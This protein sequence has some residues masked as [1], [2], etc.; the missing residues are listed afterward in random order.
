MFSIPQFTLSH[1]LLQFI[2]IIE[3]RLLNKTVEEEAGVLLKSIICIITVSLDAGRDN[4]NGIK[5]FKRNIDK[6]DC[7]PPSK[8]SSSSSTF[9]TSSTSSSS[10]SSSSSFSSSWINSELLSCIKR[11]KLLQSEEGVFISLSGLRDASVCKSLANRIGNERADK[12]IAIAA[13]TTESKVRISIKSSVSQNILIKDSVYCEDEKDVERR[14]SLVSALTPE[15]RRLCALLS[16]SPFLFAHTVIKKLIAKGASNLAMDV[17]KS[18]ES[19]DSSA[20]SPSPLFFAVDSPV[21]SFNSEGHVGGNDLSILLEAAVTLC[22]VVAKQL[23][24]ANTNRTGAGDR[25][26]LTSLEAITRPFVV[27][28]DLLKGVASTCPPEH[29]GR[30]LDILNGSELVLAVHERMEGA[31]LHGQGQDHG[32]HINRLD[33]TQTALSGAGAGKFKVSEGSFSR[34]GILMA[35]SSVLG[36]V[37]RY[38]AA[39]IRRRLSTIASTT[40][41]ANG[42]AA[43]L[44]LEELVCVLQRSENHLLAVRV[45]LSSWHLSDTKA[46]LLRSSL[47]SLSRKVLSYR[48]IDTALAVAC[49][50]MLPYDAMVRELK[51]AVPSIQSD[52]SRLRTVAS[53]GEGLARL[54]DQE[55]LLVVFQGLQTNAKWWHILSQHGVKIDPRAFQSSDTKQRDLCVRAVVPELLELSN[56]DLEQAADYCRQFDIEPEFAS[57]SYIEKIMLQSPTGV[58]SGNIL[59]VN[60][61]VWAR[62]VRKATVN[63]DERA[64]LGTLRSLL[65]RIHPLDYER[66]RFMCTWIVAALA[67]EVETEEDITRQRSTENLEGIA[68]GEE[69]ASLKPFE[70]SLAEREEDMKGIGEGK[71]GVRKSNTKAR[72][73]SYS[74]KATEEAEACRRYADI[75]TYLAGLSFPL[76][77]TRS[78]S[79]AIDE[80]SPATVT[81]TTTAAASASSKH[82]EDINTTTTTTTVTDTSSIYGSTVS[83]GWESC[84]TGVSSAYQFRIP[85]WVREIFRMI[86]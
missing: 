76:E 2:G 68:D 19:E 3:G 37:L 9:P 43:A 18:L 54:W 56:M 12:I 16:V 4:N 20:G 82:P 7:H 59:S 62:E 5:G 21:N 14:E 1:R 58:I 53:V 22:S 61:M 74:V 57:L 44:D 45:L 13:T 48:E 24:T 40:G 42:N 15:I 80:K 36:H 49:L 86:F 50:V 83:T 25:A 66:I 79:K 10:S 6:N 35:P 23:Q 26:G 46:Q 63:V 29:L 30:T 71:S 38:S 51:A 11:L 41:T 84:Y 70:T 72:S 65:P 52:F 8:M 73:D 60:D 64:V 85:F 81:A 39:E 47:L 28:R 34:D 55:A 31:L 75:A 32:R 77:A 69:S 67:E 33:A 27:T 17:A 78:I